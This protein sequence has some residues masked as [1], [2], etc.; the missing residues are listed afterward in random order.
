MVIQL[1]ILRINDGKGLDEAWRNEG[2]VVE[3]ALVGHCFSGLT[4][5]VDVQVKER[6]AGG[7]DREL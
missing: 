5:S 3:E 1:V 4:G 2:E 7:V 6:I